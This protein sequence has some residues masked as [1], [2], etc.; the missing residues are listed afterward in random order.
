MSRKPMLAERIKT[1][2]GVQELGLSTIARVTDLYY[3]RLLTDSLSTIGRV[4]AYSDQSSRLTPPTK[5]GSFGRGVETNFLPPQRIQH[6]RIEVRYARHSYLRS[7]QPE[8]PR[9]RKTS[10]QHRAMRSVQSSASSAG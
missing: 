3:L 10:Q 1:T 9:L 8:E 4:I 7:L 6:A 2:H 5:S